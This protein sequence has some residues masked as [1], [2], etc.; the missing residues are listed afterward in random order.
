MNEVKLFGKG[1]LPMAGEYTG[2][3]VL[4]GIGAFLGK[5]SEIASIKAL[6][7]S[8]SRVIDINGSIGDTPELAFPHQRGE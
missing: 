6:R 5:Q 1:P 4:T 3:V 2:E 8:G 7:S